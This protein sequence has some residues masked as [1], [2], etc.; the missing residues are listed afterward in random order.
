MP[1]GGVKNISKYI[2][3]KDKNGHIVG[4]WALEVGDGKIKCKFCNIALAILAGKSNLTQ[5]S[6]SQTHQSSKVCKIK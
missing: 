5:H 4:D 6:E 2:S 3:V 1:G